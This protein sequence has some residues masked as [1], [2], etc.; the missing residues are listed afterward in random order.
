IRNEEDCTLI[1]MKSYTL[2]RQ[3]GCG[4]GA[5][6]AEYILGAIPNELTINIPTPGADAKVNLDLAFVGMEVDYN[7]TTDGVYSGT[8]VSSLN[9]GFF[10]TSLNV[11][12]NKLAI[13]DPTTLNPTA[14]VAYLSEATITV[15]N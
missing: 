8:R 6:E 4:A 3:Y 5:V 10:G 12:Q 9:E 1:E 13:L 14:L 15:N 2:E 7:N 11:Y